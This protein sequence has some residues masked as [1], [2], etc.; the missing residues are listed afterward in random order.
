MKHVR[1]ND[2]VEVRYFKKNKPIHQDN[3]PIPF[4]KKASIVFFLFLILLMLINM[5]KY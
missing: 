3:I 1:F 2:V 4:F 5:T